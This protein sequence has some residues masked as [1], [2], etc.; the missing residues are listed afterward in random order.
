MK[1]SHL[2]CNAPLKYNMLRYQRELCRNFR[3]QSY[4]KLVLTDKN[5]GPA[6][7]LH[8][9]YITRACQHLKKRKYIKMYLT[10]H[11]DH[12]AMRYMRFTRELYVVHRS[13]LQTLA[14]LSPIYMLQL[15]TTSIGSLRYIRHL[16]DYVL[17]SA[18]LMALLLAW[19]NGWIIIYNHICVNNLAT[20]LIHNSSSNICN[21][22]NGS[23]ACTCTS[24]TPN[25][26]IRYSIR[27]CHASHT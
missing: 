7:Q 1:S 3:S 4:F 14:F 5:L 12:C 15:Q 26:S 8:D 6:L 27:H 20:Y 11:C 16:W 23:L 10:Y 18:K 17:I 13:T 24:W 21:N 19:Q 22:C 2:V 25:R 9:D